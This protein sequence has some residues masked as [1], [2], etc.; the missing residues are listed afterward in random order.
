METVFFVSYECE[1]VVI[2]LADVCGSRAGLDWS[3]ERR[4]RPQVIPAGRM[5][6]TSWSHPFHSLVQ[7]FSWLFPPRGKVRARLRCYSKPNLVEPI[8]APCSLLVWFHLSVSLSNSLFSF[9]SLSF[10]MFYL[11][12]SLFFLSACVIVTLPDGPSRCSGASRGHRG[13]TADAS[14]R[15]SPCP[16]RQP[17]RRHCEVFFLQINLSK[18]ARTIRRNKLE[19]RKSSN[20]T[21]EYYQK[22][23]ELVQKIYF[24]S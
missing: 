20:N 5:C 22:S 23:V 7:C 18:K 11:F 12:L 17:R 14:F 1:F 21:C 2:R 4:R 15:S 3:G 19:K 8:A 10:Y 6:T 9:L 13:S 16:S 24:V